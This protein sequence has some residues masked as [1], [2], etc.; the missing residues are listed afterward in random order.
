MTASRAEKP[1]NQSEQR[2]LA[3]LARNAAIGQPWYTAEYCVD[4][5]AW[6]ACFSLARR[7][8]VTLES[9]IGCVRIRAKTEMVRQ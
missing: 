5:R 8:M 4:R 2:V 3:A 1:L 9:A 7:G 6:N